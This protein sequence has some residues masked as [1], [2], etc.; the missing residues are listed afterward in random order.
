[1]EEHLNF[2]RI[3]DTPYF[4]WMIDTETTAELIKLLNDRGVRVKY[5]E[6]E[7]LKFKGNNIDVEV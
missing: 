5:T 1:M 6:K 3:N 2:V 4:C 7:G